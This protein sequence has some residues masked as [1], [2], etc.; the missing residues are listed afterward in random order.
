MSGR[1]RVEAEHA[2][3]AEIVRS[4]HD[5]IVS[6][7]TE[8]RITSWNSGAEA[9]YGYSAEEVMGKSSDLLIPA[10]ATLESRGL[11][12]RMTAGGEVHRYETKRLRKDGTLIEVAI[13]GFPL[14]DAAGDA[15]GA[16]RS[17]ATSLRTSGRAR[18]GRERGALS[19]DPRHDS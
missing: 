1:S 18:A 7:D 16:P 15:Y 2:R 19:R 17:R 14:F 3:L 6:I 9:M 5:A 13:T 11:R 4:S 10:D 12:E 8:L